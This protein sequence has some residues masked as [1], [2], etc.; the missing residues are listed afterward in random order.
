MNYGELFEKAWRIIWK[1]KVLWIFGIL[2][3]CSANNGSGPRDV[4]QYDLGSEDFSGRDPFS[5]MFP[6]LENFFYNLERGFQDGSAWPALIGIGL[7][8]LCVILIFWVIGLV[9]GTFG[10]TGLVRGAWL[11]DEGAARLSFG[12]L[13]NDAR[14]YFWRVLG[15][16]LLLMVLGW[17]VGIILILPIIFFAVLTL[18]CGLIL[19][20]PLLVI[21]GWLISVW[22][23]LT[24]IAIVGENLSIMDGIRRA[25]EV[26]RSNLGP[27]IV[28]SLIIFIGQF[29]ITLLIGLPF[30]IVIVPI[31]AG[32]LSQTNTGVVTGLIT[33]G[34]ILLIYLPIAIILNGALQTYVGTIWTLFFRR[35]TG[36]L[37]TGSV[38][39]AAPSG[40]VAYDV[41]DINE[42]RVG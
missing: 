36:R 13:W 14:P 21:V 15:L 10:R 24:I 33:A 23:E 35:N 27:T 11:A 40:A 20:I 18:G 3:G 17:V 22:L 41:E 1:H 9:L 38:E 31:A 39:P 4:L 25:W 42:P 30:L 8:L 34:V 19:I 28:V 2:A 12:Q 37:A 6:G 16:T 5:Q 29:I 7:A 32:F 26:I